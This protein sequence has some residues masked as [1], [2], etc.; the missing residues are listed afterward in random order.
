[1]AAFSFYPGKNLGAYGE[2]GAVTTDRDD[3]AKTVRALRDW[4][5]EIKGVHALM[6]FNFR[7]EGIQ[8]AIL[9][10]KMDHIEAWTEARQRVALRYRELLTGLEGV[11]LPE[12]AEGRRHVHHVY[13][14]LVANRDRVRQSLTDEG[15]STGIHYP[16][17]VHLQPCFAYLG[18]RRGDFPVAER[19]AEMELSLPMFPEMTDDQIAHT[20]QAVRRATHD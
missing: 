5:Q 15:V 3:L 18:H 8:G 17:P 7:M 11:A 9:A 2:G 19:V 4:G 14:I 1:M 16:L 13:A 20:A 6:G 10:V 12:V